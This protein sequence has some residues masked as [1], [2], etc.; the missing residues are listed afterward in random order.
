MRPLTRRVAVGITHQ[1]Y[2]CSVAWLDSVAWFDVQFAPHALADHAGDHSPTKAQLPDYR[3][4]PTALG[5]AAFRVVALNDARCT[6]R[7]VAD[8]DAQGSFGHTVG[9]DYLAPP[10]RATVDDGVCDQ[11]TGDRLKI[12]G[13]MIQSPPVRDSACVGASNLGSGA[14]A[15]ISDLL[16]PRNDHTYTPL[17][18]VR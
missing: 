15:S 16:C 1:R 11:F 17:A 6:G 13:Q 9:D 14:N 10:G 4:A 3:Q 2:V 8:V 7:P 18:W 5:D 12:I